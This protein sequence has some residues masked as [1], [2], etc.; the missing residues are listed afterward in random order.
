MVWEKWWK[1]DRKKAKEEEVVKIPTWALAWCC[2]FNMLLLLTLFDVKSRCEKFSKESL[3]LHSSN[4]LTNFV[5]CAH[6][7]SHKWNGI[8]AIFVEIY[9]Y[10]LC[11]YKVAE[12]FP[13]NFC[14]LFSQKVVSLSTSFNIR[15]RA[16]HNSQPIE[17]STLIFKWWRR[18]EAKCFWWIE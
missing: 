4:T 10:R 8:V 14:A 11:S 18:I 16:M 12:W 7:K 3:V 6:I 9:S 13:H 17:R 1:I 15:E 5:H 2:F